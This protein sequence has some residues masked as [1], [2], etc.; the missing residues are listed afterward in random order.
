M[1]KTYI[2]PINEQMKVGNLIV[3]EDVR[4]DS[5][6]IPNPLSY[7][8]GFE[9]F[10]YLLTVHTTETLPAKYASVVLVKS[11]AVMSAALGKQLYD[12][13]WFPFCETLQE[14]SPIVMTQLGVYDEKYKEL[15][16][17]EHIIRFISSLRTSEPIITDF[18]SI[19]RL[20]GGK[21]E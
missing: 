20:A 18:A 15:F 5:T 6:M 4:V 17:Q 21:N 8:M 11:E 13:H 3:F 14:S 19:K 10:S 12:V 2:F 1:I 9:P 7:K 16:G